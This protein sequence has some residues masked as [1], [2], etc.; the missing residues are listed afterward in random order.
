MFKYVLRLGVA[1]AT[2]CVKT[3]SDN[4]RAAANDSCTYF[5][6]MLT[7]IYEKCMAIMG[8][9]GGGGTGN[10]VMVNI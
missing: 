10:H 8:G 5:E 1:F 3:T 6:A 2:Y 4:I 9:G 7:V